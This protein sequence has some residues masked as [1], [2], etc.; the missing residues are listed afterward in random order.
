MSRLFYACLAMTTALCT[1]AAWAN[2]IKTVGTGI[3]NDGMTTVELRSGYS[4]DDK[5]SPTHDGRFQTRQLV[6][7]GFNDWYALRLTAI[8][9]NRG[10]G[11]YEHDIAMVD[12][13]IQIFERAKHGFDGGFRLTYMLR[14]GDKKP[15][16]AEARWINH[17][18]FWDTYEF[19]HHVIV[20]HQVG[21][22]SRSGIMPELR[23]QVT[24]PL[25]DKHRVGVEMF[26][27]FGNL[28]DDYTYDQQ[29][30]DA[31]FLLTGPLIG[32][33][34]YHAGY[35]HGLSE[36]APDHA[37]KFFVGYDF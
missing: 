24:R 29:S 28:R 17:I 9:D 2:P 31:G 15:D 5:A 18:P 36:N 10:I 19:R 23:W 34:R 11:E 33:T 37:V 4:I 13:R 21:P 20:Q 12:N 30:H 26:N 14:D 8:Q 3:V 35:R 32:K 16:I 22:D 25:V 1:S 7:H 6:D 27:E